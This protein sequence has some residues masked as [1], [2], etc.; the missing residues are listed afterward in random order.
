MLLKY[1]YYQVVLGKLIRYSRQI[2]RS[3][4]TYNGE[5]CGRTGPMVKTCVD[6]GNNLWCCSDYTVCQTVL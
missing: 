4:K 2:R 1:M 3:N 5:R 6:K